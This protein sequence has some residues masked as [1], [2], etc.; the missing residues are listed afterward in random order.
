MVALNPEALVKLYEAS[1]ER[2]ESRTIFRGI[3][4]SGKTLF[5]ERLSC[6]DWVDCDLSGCT[7]DNCDLRGSAFIECS[8]NRA[9]FVRC[10]VYGSE[11]PDDSTLHLRDCRKT[12]CGC[13]KPCPSCLLVK[14]SE[15]LL[16]GEL[17]IGS[18][19]T[20]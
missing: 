8:L 5:S 6:I 2:G 16:F 14:N 11:F 18:Q 1:I 15:S 19:V 10:A 9:R 7:F 20:W 4:L 3:D 12:L 13:K 17:A